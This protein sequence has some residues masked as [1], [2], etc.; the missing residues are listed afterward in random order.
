MN[1]RTLLT[2]EQF[3]ENRFEL[4]D[5]GRWVE[6]VNGEVVILDSPGVEHG[7][8]VLNLSKMLAS[9]LQDPEADDEGY[10]CYDLGLVVSRNPDTVH[11]PTMS[12]LVGGDR[13]S[14]A[15]ET[16]TES[17]P[18]LVVEIASTN[19]RRRDMSSRVKAYHAL[20]VELVW[21][22]DPIGKNLHVTEPGKPSKKL[23]SHHTLSGGPVLPGFKVRVGRLF[24]EPTWWLG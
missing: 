9:H 22:A 2:A 11:F 17:P 18:A 16:M 13:F 6:L 4:P 8:A 20:G 24:A 10:V 3:A 7:D 1:T 12:Y 23:S 15:D 21:V 14:Q 5:G 19:L